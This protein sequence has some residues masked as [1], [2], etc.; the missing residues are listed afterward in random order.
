M[1]LL[2]P[3]NLSTQPSQVPERLYLILYIRHI[4][5]KCFEE[6]QFSYISLVLVLDQFIRNCPFFG[7]LDSMHAS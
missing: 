1:E 7:I 2:E 6:E 4:N 5:Q 3:L